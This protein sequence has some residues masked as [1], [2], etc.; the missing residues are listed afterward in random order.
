MVK[1]GGGLDFFWTVYEGDKV[2]GGNE[3][4]GD[5]CL[6]PRVEISLFQN[7]HVGAKVEKAEM[8]ETQDF[9]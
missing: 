5:N 3:T 1:P 2:V 4:L 7:V 9:D 6:L 8:S